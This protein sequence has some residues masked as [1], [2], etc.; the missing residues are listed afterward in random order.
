MVPNPSMSADAITRTR[1]RRMNVRPGRE[2]DTSSPTSPCRDRFTTA[3]TGVGCYTALRQ[4]QAIADPGPTRPPVGAVGR[5]GYAV[6]LTGMDD[7]TSTGRGRVVSASR[8][9]R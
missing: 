9:R 4:H 3:S 1:H 5:D 6:A 8:Q 2:L 7:A